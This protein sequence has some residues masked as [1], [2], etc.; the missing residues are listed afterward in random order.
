MEENVDHAAR[1]REEVRGRREDIDI[2]LEGRVRLS[3]DELAAS[4]ASLHS[5]R[6]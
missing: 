2:E 4:S 6:Q 5:T 1:H 3:S